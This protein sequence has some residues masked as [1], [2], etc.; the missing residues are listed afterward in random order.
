MF[1]FQ[2]TNKNLD[3]FLDVEDNKPKV[4]LFSPKATP[5]LLYHAVGFANQ[6]RLSF[7]FVSTSDA[8]G[9]KLRRKFKALPNEPSV[10]IFKEEKSVPEVVVEV[11]IKK[12]FNFHF[13]LNKLF[14]DNIICSTPGIRTKEW[15]TQGDCRKQQVLN[16]SKAVFPKSFS[17]FVSR[18]KIQISKKVS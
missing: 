12:I 10:L 2:V 8:N 9:E 1:F 16:T 6:K 11:S 5:S 3:S 17:G 7:G 4:L 18:R 14:G 15:K 13:T